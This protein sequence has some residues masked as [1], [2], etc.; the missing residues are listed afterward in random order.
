MPNV[1]VRRAYIKFR[2]C[3]ERMGGQ[4]RRRISST[5]FISNMEGIVG[6]DSLAAIFAVAEEENARKVVLHFKI[7]GC[8]PLNDANLLIMYVP[9][10][11]IVEPLRLEIRINPD[12]VSA[13]EFMSSQYNKLVELGAQVAVDRN[14][15][16]AVFSVQGKPA[17]F[18]H[19]VL[20]YVC[21]VFRKR[22]NIEGL[23]LVYEGFTLVKE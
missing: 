7:S 21:E 1:W 19:D 13:R 11:D 5:E 20:G 15:I 8:E 23:N 12:K 16:Y 17:E 4:E 14:G 3:G 18:L 9:Y 6:S 10:V 2:R 22:R